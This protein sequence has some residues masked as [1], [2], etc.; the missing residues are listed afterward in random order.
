MGFGGPFET[1]KDEENV[2]NDRFLAAARVRKAMRE[3][4]RALVDSV[5]EDSE[6]DSKLFGMMIVQSL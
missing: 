4:M 3:A 2:L 1:R 5:L 6:R